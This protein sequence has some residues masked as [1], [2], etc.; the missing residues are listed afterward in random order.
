MG[1]IA[2]EGRLDGVFGEGTTCIARTGDGGCLML[3]CGVYGVEVLQVCVVDVERQVRERVFFLGVEGFRGRVVSEFWTMCRFD[4][5]DL[6]EN[7]RV[8][9]IGEVIVRVHCRG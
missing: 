4:D 2:K 6:V 9:D 7:S 3:V 1:N 8:E 5:I